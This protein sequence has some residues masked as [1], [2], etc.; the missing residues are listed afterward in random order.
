M[1]TGKDR[2]SEGVTLSPPVH[3]P[4]AFGCVAVFMGLLGWVA[5][6]AGGFQRAWW[7]ILPTWLVALLG[8][9]AALV[10][11][12]RRHA[13]ELRISP[14]RFSFAGVE[15]TRAEVVRVRRHR[16]LMFKGVRADLADGRS[17]GI[18]AS[19]HD[20]NAVLRAFT[21]NDYPVGM[22]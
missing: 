8:A 12:K 6:S 10:T 20:P 22:E 14:E 7:G 16:D 5:L 17:L 11:F 3:T 1:T 21:E 9:R 19:H 2:L 4:V 13:L 15:V 18:S